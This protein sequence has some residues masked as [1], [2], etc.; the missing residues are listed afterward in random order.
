MTT[1]SDLWNQ[2]Q[3]VVKF[4]DSLTTNNASNVKTQIAS[5]QS[6][7]SGDHIAETDSA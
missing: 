5:I 1:K 2:L 4:L 6:Q 3:Y 7:Y